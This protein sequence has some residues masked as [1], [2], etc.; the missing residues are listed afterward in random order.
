MQTEKLPIDID[1]DLLNPDADGKSAPGK[2]E[3][4][5]IPTPLKEVSKKEASKAAADLGLSKMAV[6][7]LD[8]QAIIGR[9]IE[10]AGAIRITT[11]EFMVSNSV[12]DELIQLCLASVR[13]KP[14]MK[15]LLQVGAFL[16]KLLESKDNALKIIN[17]AQNSGMLKPAQ[18]PPNNR[19]PPRGAQITPVQ[20]NNSNVTLTPGKE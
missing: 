5:M 11:G 14:S 8:A 12:R 17:Q 10:Q 9:Y 20:I 2:Q 19:L 7:N 15:T 1:A 13:S 3:L 4:G 18:D 6:G 16:N